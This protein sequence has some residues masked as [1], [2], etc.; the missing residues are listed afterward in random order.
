MFSRMSLQVNPGDR[1]GLVG[2]NGAGKSTLLRLLSG[3]L[4]PDE[5]QRVLAR[6]KRFAYL[7]Q[8][9]ELSGQGTLWDILLAPF[10]AL[11]KL[12]EDVSSFENKL[13][14]ANC[15]EEDVRSYGRLQEQYQRE[16]GYLVES[17]VRSI[18]SEI[19]FQPK[20]LERSVH[21]FSGGERGRVELAKIL[22]AAPDVLLLDEPTNHLDLQ[23]IEAL[24]RRL[25]AW[26]SARAFV[27]VSHDRYFLEAV[28][29]SIVEVEHQNV[30]VYPFSYQ[31]YLKEREKRH[32]LQMKAF[33][34]QQEEIAKTEE[35]I[36]RNIAGQNTKQAQGRRKMLEK[37][38][39]IERPENS[40]AKAK[41]MK[42]GFSQEGSQGGKEL[43]RFKDM[44]LTYGESK[45]LLKGFSKT[46]YRGERIALIGPN[47]AGKS[48]VLKAI[49]GKVAPSA[50]HIEY[51]YGLQL[52]YFDQHLS[53]VVETNTLL[54][55]IHE[56][57]PLWKEEEVRSY[58][59][60]FRFSGEDA[61][62]KVKEL[63]G[64]E[65]NRLTL[66]KLMLEPYNLLLL[67][68]PTNHL[69]LPT[70][71]NLEAALK[72]FE[73]T[74]L[75]VSH[76]RFFLNELV[77]KIWYLDPQTA[78][79][80]EY[81][82]NYSEWKEWKEKQALSLRPSLEKNL[83][84]SMQSASLKEKSDYELRKEMERLLAKKRKEFTQTEAKITELENAL[85]QIQQ[86]ILNHDPSDWQGLQ[87]F[88]EEEKK[89]QLDLERLMARWEQL[90]QELG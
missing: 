26:D 63:S 5:G 42:L 60:R 78:Q 34:E 43:L 27:I 15:T 8:S 49:L 75:V 65:R 40:F 72:S 30:V 48:T 23:S 89:L 59:G 68:E 25:S 73:G 70:C 16:E 74:L 12:R 20:D 52:G 11:L 24:E 41:S 64:G 4:I 13:S 39:R 22:L 77:Q 37:L 21:T 69:D 90:G 66:A 79:I 19:G 31:K 61:F 28:C 9:Q 88:S 2:P 10:S 46:I 84:A 3:A 17:K 7:H 71:E 38:E 1:I 45:S 67:D 51:G 54:E 47:G 44:E 85:S 57:R 76:D 86:T 87:A 55:E 36:R 53:S 82:G 6:G 35:F 81:L 56:V 50:G 18:A 83:S 14:Q 62:R 33:L 29:T 32:D 58:L 80:E